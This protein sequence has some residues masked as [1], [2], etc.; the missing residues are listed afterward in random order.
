MVDGLPARRPDLKFER[1]GIGTITDRS[2]GQQKHLGLH[3]S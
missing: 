3:L 1:G 2:L